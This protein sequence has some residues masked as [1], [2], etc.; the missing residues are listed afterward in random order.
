[1]DRIIWEENVHL[2]GAQQVRMKMQP[3]SELDP[4]LLGPKKVLIF[5]KEVNLKELRALG[6]LLETE[7][8]ANDLTRN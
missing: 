4:V 8:N 3:I 2:S 1:M 7:N 6:K 5:L